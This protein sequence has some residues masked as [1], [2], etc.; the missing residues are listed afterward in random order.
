MGC[1][2][3]YETKVQTVKYT[4][5]LNKPKPI[6]SDII[7]KPPFIK[8]SF[9]SDFLKGMKDRVDKSFTDGEYFRQ[10]KDGQRNGKGRFIWVTKGDMYEGDWKDDMMHGKGLYIFSNGKVY[11]GDWFEGEMHGKGVMK[12]SDGY[13]E[14]DWVHDKREGKGKFFYTADIE[15]GDI[16]EGE[17]RDDEKNGKGIY[18]YANGDI[19]EGEWKDDEE[20]EELKYIQRGEP[21]K[22]YKK[23]ASKLAKEI[24][25]TMII[26]I[27][28]LNKKQK[29]VSSEI[30]LV[31]ALDI[32]ERMEK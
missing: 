11:Y 18:K 12:Y 20:I 17:W 25:I 32:S 6:I 24:T 16:Y 4:G 7:F 3:S 13:Y 31:L 21:C 30:V 19:Y 2:D 15:K 8:L 29:E 10:M 14:G 23:N 26:E 9:S 5:D 1:S 28:N 27:K 22:Y